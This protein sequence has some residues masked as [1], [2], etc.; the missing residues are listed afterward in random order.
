MYDKICKKFYVTLPFT[1]SDRK[2]TKILIE[3]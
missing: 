3:Y 2:D 1:L